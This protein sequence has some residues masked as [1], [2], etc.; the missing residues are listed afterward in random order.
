MHDSVYF[1]LVSIQHLR[2]PTFKLGENSYFGLAEQRVKN[3]I[4]H[5]HF[6]SAADGRLIVSLWR[7]LTRFLG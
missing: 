7:S 2:V 3:Q 5:L 4:T 1:I 6:A